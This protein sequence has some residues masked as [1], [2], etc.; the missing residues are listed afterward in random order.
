MNKGK[1]AS[2]N[3]IKA[4]GAGILFIALAFV[5]QYVLSGRA[6]SQAVPTSPVSFSEVMTA[7]ASAVADD[8]GA[9]SDWFEIVNDSERAVDLTGWMVLRGSEKLDVYT[10]G[11]QWIGPNEH[12]VV[13]ASGRSQ[14]DRQSHGD[15]LRKHSV[16]AKKCTHH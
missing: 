11:R 4:L 3:L 16:Q 2:G 5:W 8:Y 15:L 13:F 1:S 9:Y 10:F 14:N 7:N 12:I 6:D